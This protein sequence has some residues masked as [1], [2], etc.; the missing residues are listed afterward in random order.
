MKMKKSFLVLVFLSMIAVSKAQIGINTD[1]VRGVFHIDGKGNNSS[2][3]VP[4]AS[5]LEDDAVFKLTGDKQLVLGLGGIPS[6]NAQLHLFSK[7]KGLLLNKVELNSSSDV[8]TVPAPQRGMI[9]YNTKGQNDVIEDFHYFN[10]VKWN[11]ARSTKM[12][13]TTHLNLRTNLTIT[14]STAAEANAATLRGAMLDFTL[15][16]SIPIKE[17]GPYVFC[18]RVYGV[19]NTASISNLPQL[20]YI[21]M[22]RKSDKKVLDSSTH[23]TTVNFNTSLSF[24]SFLGASLTE[25]EDVE[26]YLAY[27]GANNV[28]YSFSARAESD[29][30]PNRMSL[31]YWKL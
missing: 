11:V 8:S 1:N 18:I 17:S 19:C 24:T 16:K 4:S 26:F 9:V 14:S 15:T 6:D 30:Y 7:T 5:Q 2:T 29:T 10:G 12:S 20:F 28:T 22:V 31:F 3:G 27:Q 21:Y 23:F 13:G 25:G